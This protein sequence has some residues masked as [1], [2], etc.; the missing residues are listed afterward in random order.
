MVQNAEKDAVS[1]KE[2]KGLPA[3]PTHAD[4]IILEQKSVNLQQ[5]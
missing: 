3:Q 5:S 2:S 4:K 1:V